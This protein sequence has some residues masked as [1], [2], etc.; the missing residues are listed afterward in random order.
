MSQNN[1]LSRRHFLKTSAFTAFS[2]FSLSACTTSSQSESE[3]NSAASG[4]TTDNTKNPKTTKSDEP[5]EVNVGDTFNISD[6]FE[7]TLS[8][9][10]WT[11]E[12]LPS[13]TSGFYSYL[14]DQ[15]EKSW[16]V[17]YGTIKNIGTETYSFGGTSA[18]HLCASIMMNGKYKI[19]ASIK[20]DKGTGFDSEIEPLITKPLLIISSVSDEI[21]ESFESCDLTITARK[22]GEDGVWH[23]DE[24]VGEYKAKFI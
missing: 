24:I 22:R 11:D 15:E 18:N 2:L 3:D 9:A 1:L 6:M 12:V 17:I 5:V 13:D 19:E 21:K 23:T 20:A 16:Y 4:S 14:E 10:E 8:S 7:V